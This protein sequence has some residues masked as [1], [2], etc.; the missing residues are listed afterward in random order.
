MSDETSGRATVSI[1]TAEQSD[2]SVDPRVFG[3]FT[4]MNGREAYP[5]IYS[6]HLANGSFEEWYTWPKRP[7]EDAPDWWCRTEVVH[8]DVDREPNVAYPWESRRD[9]RV[10]F[11]H[12]VGGVHGR[13]ATVPPRTDTLGREHREPPARYQRI[14]VWEGEGGVVQRLALPDDRT[15]EYVLEL[16]VRGDGHDE[17][18]IE[19]EGADGTVLAREL[20]PVS[21]EWRR[22]EVTLELDAESDDRYENSAFGVHSL[23]LSVEGRGHTDLD[24]AKLRAGDAVNEKF[25]P[26]AIENIREYGVPSIRWPGGNFTSQYHWR[27]GVGPLEERPVRTELHWGGLE[28]NY[29]GT[30][31]FL[32]FCELA[33]VHPYLNVGFSEHIS[34]VE[35]ADWVEYVNGDPGETKMGS[36]R[37]EHGYEEPWGVDVFQVGNEVWGTFQI[38]HTEPDEYGRRFREYYD[39]ITGV[40][41]GIDVAATALDPGMHTWGGPGWNERFFEAGGRV[42]D[43]IDIH[44]YV[45]GEA[46]GDADVDPIAFNQQLVLFPTQFEENVE[47]LRET[48]AEYDADPDVTV[49]EWNMGAGGL[50]DGP[51]AKYGTMAHAAFCAGMYNAF[52]RQGDAVR[53]GHQRD[54]SFKHRPFPSDLRPF[55]TANNAAMRLYTE[56]LRE[57]DWHHIPAAVDGPGGDI[58]RHGERIRAQEDTPYVDAAAVCSGDDV[59]VFLVNRDLREVRAA[60]VDLGELA[61][62]DQVAVTVQRADDP[63]DDTCEWDGTVCYELEERRIEADARGRV[64]VDLPPAGVARADATLD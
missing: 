28:P 57:G 13:D 15:L 20:V 64:V 4:E 9:G 53:F 46:D 21:D 55:E 6:E 45:H 7:R 48:A 18:E 54:N 42:A 41:P 5:G 10:T 63:L 19:M 62:G 61:P 58:D 35:A 36:L 50:P 43:G 52:L 32:E 49:G 56:R 33:D 47:R 3:K 26:T 14:T 30:N 59:A 12:L 40:D 8:R 22:H 11:E 24:W 44:R 16:S 37:A 34:P 51:R 38:G 23:V 31:E 1:D 25:N 17:V 2:W 60:V 27:D 39:A 29:L